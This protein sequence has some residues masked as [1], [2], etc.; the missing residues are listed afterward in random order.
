[1]TRTPLQPILR[2]LLL[3]AGLSQSSAVGNVHDLEEH[4]A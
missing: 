1:M 3:A 4:L 2:H